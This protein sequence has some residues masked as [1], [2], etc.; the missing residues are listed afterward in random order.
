MSATGLEHETVSWTGSN[1]EECSYTS[2]GIAD[3]SSWSPPGNAVPPL[4]GTGVAV[5]SGV[6][7]DSSGGA[8]LGV[9]GALSHMLGGDHSQLWFGHARARDGTRWLEDDRRSG[10][11][12]VTGARWHA[13]IPAST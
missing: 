10:R 1:D 3:A 11:D 5:G 12:G 9:V 8:G 7:V 2:I 4:L 6:N 13:R